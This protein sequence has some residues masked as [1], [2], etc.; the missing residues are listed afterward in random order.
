M[1]RPP[2][3][4]YYRGSDLAAIMERPRVAVVGSRLISPYGRQV[5]RQLVRGLAG[6]GVVIISGLAIGVDAQAHEAA[7]SVGGTTVAVLPSPVTAV[8]PSVNR[9]LAAQ[10]L[11][12]QGGL[13]SAYPPGSSNHKGNFVARNEL[14]AALSNLV[15]ITEAAQ[16]SGSLHTAAFAHGIGIEVHAVP[17]NITSPMSVGTNNLIK[18]GQAGTITDYHDVL[19]LLNMQQ[20]S[21]TRRPTGDTPEQQRLLDLLNQAISNGDELLQLS[22]LSVPV[23]NQTL[24]MLEMS[25]RI[26]PLG[27][28]RWAL[29]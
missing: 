19:R 23:F 14:V 16:K 26:V 18:S 28:N 13:L 24:T 4:L 29:A 1:H 20:P 25:A 2:G 15:I 5:T 11:E 6:A 12:G 7:L 21:V 17:G 22:Q 27:A 9:R 8:T 10:I 3:T